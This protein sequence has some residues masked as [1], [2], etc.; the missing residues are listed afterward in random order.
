MV[1]SN[2][3]GNTDF[4]TPETAFLVDGKMRPLKAGDYLGW[5][6]Q[7]WF[8]ADIEHAAAQLHACATDAQ[9]AKRKAAAGRALIEQRHNPHAVGQRYLQRLAEVG[10]V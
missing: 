9:A 4:C 3:S 7:S 10:L 5:Q 1:V 6:G 2:Y 8:D